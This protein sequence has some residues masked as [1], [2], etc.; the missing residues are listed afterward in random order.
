[1]LGAGGRGAIVRPLSPT[2]SGTPGTG[3][4]RKERSFRASEV[5]HL[6]SARRQHNSLSAFAA[7]ASR[8][9]SFSRVSLAEACEHVRANLIGAAHSGA[10]FAHVRLNGVLNAGRGGIVAKVA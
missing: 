1:M 2:D 4:A 3:E 5:L 10:V 7:G 6:V 8:R 9:V